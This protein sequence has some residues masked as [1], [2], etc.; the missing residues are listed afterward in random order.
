MLS[1]TYFLFMTLFLSGKMKLKIFR[2]Y[3]RTL[4]FNWLLFCVFSWGFCIEHCIVCIQEISVLSQCRSLYIT[5][6]YGSYLHETKLWIIMEYM[7]GG[8]VADLVSIRA[9]IVSFFLYS[10][11]CVFYFIWKDL[12]FSVHFTFIS[13]LLCC[14][15][16]MILQ[17]VCWLDKVF[18]RSL[19]C[20]LIWYFD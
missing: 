16:Q 8:S 15:L 9:I 2:R 11:A 19:F 13:T 4:L 7:A 14:W 12:Y 5:E 3:L 10:D 20:L 1:W 18:W 6:Y 17:W